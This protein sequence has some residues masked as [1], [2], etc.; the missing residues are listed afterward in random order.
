MV[1]T[2]RVAVTSASIG[3]L[4]L[5]VKAAGVTPVYKLSLDGKVHP[6]A[7]PAARA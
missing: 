6:F 5:G 4:P 2:L 3:E 1:G 7:P